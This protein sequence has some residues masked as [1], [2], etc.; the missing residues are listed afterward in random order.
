MP[1][2]L[3]VVDSGFVLALLAEDDQHHARAWELLQDSQWDFRLPPE[4]F[5]EVFHTRIRRAVSAYQSRAYITQAFADVLPWLIEE[6]PLMLEEMTTDDY[7]RV[8]QLLSQYADSGIDYVD[9][10]IVA[11]A[12][13]LRTRYIMTTDERDFRRYVPNFASYFILPV[14]DSVP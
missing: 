4:V 1:T 5:V 11:M 10:V 3:A 12:E 6:S 13:R 9:A 2:E 14:F 8:A 7:Q